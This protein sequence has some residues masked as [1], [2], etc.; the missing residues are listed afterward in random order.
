MRGLE[1]IYGDRHANT[2]TDRHF[3]TMNRPGVRAGPI[4]KSYA[5][6][7]DKKKLRNLLG[8]KNHTTSREKNNYATSRD[9]K[10]HATSRD[11]KKIMKPLGAKELCNLS[12]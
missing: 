10:N 7:C 12:Q 5:T 4:E 1:K 11:K 8:E 2:Q 6:S 9:K 3:N